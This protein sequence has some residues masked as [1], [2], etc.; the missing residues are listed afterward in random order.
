MPVAVLSRS[1]LLFGGLLAAGVLSLVLLGDEWL[2]LPPRNPS[3]PTSVDLVSWNLQ[4]GARTPEQA[5]AVLLEHRAD[6][7]ALQEL[8]NDAAAAIGADPT[9]RDWYP[10]QLL[11][12][13]PGVTG[14]GF[15]SAHPLDAWELE[16]VRP[17]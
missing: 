16:A 17:R 15:L 10:W 5:V 9:L 13:N 14:L 12:P 1:R 2:S 11:E 6:I 4:L 3:T 7:I 8:T